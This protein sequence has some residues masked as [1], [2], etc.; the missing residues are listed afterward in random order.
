MS[1]EIEWSRI[2][3]KNAGVTL[4]DCD[5]RTPPAAEDGYPYIAIPQLKNGHIELDGVRKI[6]KEHFSDWTKKLKPQADDVIVVRRCNSGD[7]A[8]VPKGLE[9]AIG[10]NLVVLRTDGKTVHPKF[11]RWLLRGPDWWDQVNKYINVGAVFDSL[12]CKEIPHFELT[13]PPIGEQSKIAEILGALD[14]RITLLR[15]TNTTLEAIAQ[16]L[17][18][19][20]F[21]DFDPIHAKQQGRIPEGMDEAAAALFPDSFEESELGVVPRGWQVGLLGTWLSALETGRRPKGGVSGIDSGVPSIGAESII[22]VGEFDFAKTK[23]VSDEFFDKMKAGRLESRDVLLYKDGGKPGVFL[24]RVSMFGDGFPYEIC[25]INE[26]VFRIRLKEPFGQTF[27]Y[28]WLWSDAIMHE[29]KHR[30]GKAAIPGINQSDVKEQRLLIPDELVL[31][32]FDELTY[33]LISRI[34]GNAKQIQ[35]LTNLRDTLLPRLISGQL[36]LP[37]VEAMVEQA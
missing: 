35:T 22:R 32:K 30:G 16:A 10:Q 15:E 31:G 36:R 27:L 1:S 13:I 37:E 23:Y 4:I 12:K 5:H 14:D 21:V 28:F 24:P 17:F 33:P 29:L 19:S 25:G 2:P 20:W 34:F 6:S 26:H 8:V 18:K 9:C 11:L 3:L 7:S